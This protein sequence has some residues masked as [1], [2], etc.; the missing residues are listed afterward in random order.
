MNGDYTQP[1]EGSSSLPA[2]GA[3]YGR[4][5]GLGGA[6]RAAVPLVPG[7]L[8]LGRAAQCGW[9]CDCPCVSSLH[10]EIT[11]TLLASDEVR[12]SVRDLRSTNGTWINGKCKFVLCAPVSGASRTG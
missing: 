8:T 3:E 1:F 6:T 11:V 4:L 5:Q 12:V 2:T 10:C 7:A 9:R